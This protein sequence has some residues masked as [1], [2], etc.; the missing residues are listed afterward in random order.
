MNIIDD[1][2]NSWRLNNAIHLYLLDRL[3]ENDLVK[4]LNNKGKSIASQ[5]GHIH[6]IRVL[7]LKTSSGNPM[8]SQATKLE[9]DSL[10]KHLLIQS[11]SRSSEAVMILLTNGFNNNKIKNT[12]LNPVLF[13]TYLVA[14]ENH[15]RG[16]IIS[17]MKNN[18]IP[19][20]KS[21]YFDIWEW[22]KFL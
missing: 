22:K 12:S 1:V 3:S 14:H 21:V 6:N 15:H 4:K 11:L 13:Y 20:D 5:F 18:A 9:K 8:E 10:D 19:I 16:Q 7:W 2:V 17:T